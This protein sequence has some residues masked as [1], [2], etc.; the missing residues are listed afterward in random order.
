[1]VTTSASSA[2]L[3]TL[4]RLHIGVTG[5]WAAMSLGP[6]GAVLWPLQALHALTFAAGHLAAIA[7]IAAAIP[8]RMIASAQ[9]IFTG[10]VS[11][12]LHAAILF[13]AAAIL[14]YGDIGGAYLLATL[15]AGLSLILSLLLARLWDGGH[16]VEQDVS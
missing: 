8:A 16:V 2:R 7:F 15:A 11:G 14:P 5:R 3:A 1:M 4:Y 13:L 9:G 12:T 10:V 6:D